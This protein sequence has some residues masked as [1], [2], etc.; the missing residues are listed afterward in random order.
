MGACAGCP[1]AVP[2]TPPH[3]GLASPRSM[4]RTTVNTPR[5]TLLPYRRHCC[6]AL[7][8]SI[9]CAWAAKGED[10]A[11][12]LFKQLDSNGDGILSGTEAKGYLDGD[13]N[14]DGRLTT[15]EFSDG[16]DIA[17][18]KKLDFNQDGWLSGK[19]AKGF[20][21][22]DQDGNGEITQAE[23][24][25]RKQQLQGKIPI[26]KKAPPGPL[27]IA[28]RI[29]DTEGMGI[30]LLDP[31]GNPLTLP[32]T[33]LPATTEK[34]TLAVDSKG[35]FHVLIQAQAGGASPTL[36]HLFS[37][38]GVLWRQLEMPVEPGQQLRKS[39][40][41]L[42]IDGGGIVHVFY[43][44]E[45]SPPKSSVR[46]GASHTLMMRTVN[47]GGWS[48]PRMIGSVGN[49]FGYATM[50]DGAGSLWVVWCS[51]SPVELTKSPGTVATHSGSSAVRWCRVSGGIPD[52]PAEDLIKPVF[53][54]INGGYD[55]APDSYEA[56][57]GYIA[58]DGT[59]HLIVEK[60]AS[61]SSSEEDCGLCYLTGAG[62][63]RILPYRLNGNVAR[64]TFHATL[65]P[66]PA[67]T[68]DLLVVHNDP[69]RNE[70]VS[71]LSYLLEGGLLSGNPT[72][73]YT[74]PTEKGAFLYPS[75]VSDAVTPGGHGAV[76]FCFGWR[77]FGYTEPFDG[78]W[79]RTSSGQWAAP[80]V[81]TT[82]SW[83]RERLVANHNSRS[84]TLPDPRV[85]DVSTAFGP[86]G[87]C[88]A[89]VAYQRQ[90]WGR[91]IQGMAASS[92]SDSKAFAILRWTLPG[93]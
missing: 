27:E 69:A 48:E 68:S 87:E 7:L 12:S 80:F 24:Q 42:V 45:A 22:Y 59:L 13:S 54:F 63:V 41:R 21:A 60:V 84:F 3:R 32:E 82:S 1:K 50:L 92:R 61:V 83:L 90:T 31:E 66:G 62:P 46:H 86:S 89:I 37:S 4:F 93:G 18:F 35:Q 19:E 2:Q 11:T 40:T 39:E 38:D 47:D 56:P 20:E 25:S 72:T 28:D 91:T 70:R 23:Y 33:E 44:L 81:N 74:C 5:P 51:Y 15:D 58:R 57:S 49:T 52:P 36:V 26:A 34:V 16:F 9:A 71:V 6:A 88:Y 78:Y 73:L 10:T 67:P 29:R 75:W 76:A 65:L 79:A 14:G 17:Q 53:T 64:N 55:V 30:S 8:L 85:F 43:T 77:G